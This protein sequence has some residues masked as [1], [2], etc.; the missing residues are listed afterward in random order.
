MRIVIVCEHASAK[1][2]GEA[3]L[4]LHYFRVLRRL[5]HAV[6]LVTH[7][8]TRSELQAL[9]PGE[10]R[11]LY[12]ED[13]RFHRL[14]FRI[15]ERLPSRIAYF[16]VGLASRIAV[17]LTQRRMVRRLVAD[18]R[19]EVV[20]QPMP[21]SP[22][23]PSLMF[24]L[25]APVVI[26]PMNGGMQ[27]PPAFRRRRPAQRFLGAAARG[28]SELL[29]WVLPGKRKATVVLVA[30]AR[31]RAA[32]PRAVRGDIVELVENGVDFDVFRPTGAEVSNDELATPAFD[33][34]TFL[35]LGRLVGWKR[36]D[37]LLRAFAIADDKARL[38]LLIVGSGS[39]E[40]ALRGLAA[41]LD[42][43]AA[44]E[45]SPGVVFI[46][47]LSQRECADRLGASDVL[48]LPSI[49]ECGG[50]VVLEAM[51]M[52]KPVIAT[53]WGG[54]LDYLDPSCGILVEPDGADSMQSALAVAMVRLALN[55]EERARMGGAGRAKVLHHYDWDVKVGRFLEIC[56]RA[57]TPSR[58]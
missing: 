1:F 31:T 49:L 48:V 15:G 28:F 40:A 39:E 42:I 12:V 16:S 35:Y 56:V 46:G 24:G 18:E 36:V 52:S 5:G 53:A 23:E 30:N 13:T 11:I 7:A 26:G 20:H 54:P 22:R 51:A 25:G 41:E 32:L 44:D 45:V 33:G 34:T 37:L 9:F 2:G 19:I 50:A 21:V 10:A 3:A 47:W 6:W 57:T 8:R 27:Y 55:R 17:Q 4:P 29:N 58:F 38:R 14:M 43:V